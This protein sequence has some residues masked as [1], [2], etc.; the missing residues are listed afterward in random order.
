VL[1]FGRYGLWSHTFS[2]PDAPVAEV[3]PELE[4]FGYACW[5]GGVFGRLDA[6]DELLS[7]TEHLMVATGIL[8]IWTMTADDA[9]AAFARIEQRTPQRFVLGLGVSHDVLVEPSGERYSHPFRRMV[10]Y[11]DALDAAPEPVPVD[12]RLLAALG[13]R[14][15]ELSAT[16]AAGAHPYLVT[17]EHTARAR[18]VMGP[19]AFLAPE[20]KVVLER[21]ARAAR[22]LGRQALAIYLTLPNYL[23]NLERLGFTTADFEHGGSD[24]VVDALVA[25]GDVDTVVA[26]LEE[27]HAAGAD[28]VAIQVVTEG[29]RL[30]LEQWRTLGAALTS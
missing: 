29:R 23:R 22:D 30:P 28:H 5:L 20:Q 17:P 14:M 11:L 12:R 4:S 1:G 6:V 21:D 26:R 24:R 7:V 10:E 13:P 3:A 8:S 27:H 2:A 15:L 18:E 25:W 16:R 19:R 9:A